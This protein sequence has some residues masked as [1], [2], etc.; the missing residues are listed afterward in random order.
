MISRLLCDHSRP[1]HRMYQKRLKYK[2][3]A[4]LDIRK[5]TDAN[6]NQRLKIGHQVC[7]SDKFVFAS[8]L[9]AKFQTTMIFFAL[10]ANMECC[11]L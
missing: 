8:G 11:Y 3:A 6:H 10:P 5:I 7:I 9:R 1:L 2:I 4:K